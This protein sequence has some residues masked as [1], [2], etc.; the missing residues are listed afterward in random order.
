MLGKPVKCPTL[1]RM[2]KTNWTG[3]G[4][5]QQGLLP[6]IVQLFHTAWARDFTLLQRVKTGSSIH[7]AS[8][9]TYQGLS[10]TVNSPYTAQD[11]NEWINRRNLGRR[12]GARGTSTPSNIFFLPKNS[13]RLATE[14]KRG[15]EYWGEIDGKGCLSIKDWFKTIFSPFLTWF[16]CEVPDIAPPQY[17]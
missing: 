7:P 2:R 12:L 4:R 17:Y 8:S 16:L 14:F 13:F 3:W 10:Q 11:K 5:W 9:K 6:F 15:E 1:E